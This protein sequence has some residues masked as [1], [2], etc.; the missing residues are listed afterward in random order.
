MKCI[1]EL[2]MFGGLVVRIF[3]GRGF[4]GGCGRWKMKC[5]DLV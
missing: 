5:E 4:E 3:G 1:G 2:V